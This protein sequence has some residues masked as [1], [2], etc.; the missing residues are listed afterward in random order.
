MNSSRC[1]AAALTLAGTPSQHQ[2]GRF[3]IPSGCSGS[4][5][6]QVADNPGYFYALAGG[7]LAH[8]DDMI[9]FG[10]SDGLREVG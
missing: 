8:S 10:I 3:A 6:V 1:F 7:T 9:F 5:R 4:T 2:S